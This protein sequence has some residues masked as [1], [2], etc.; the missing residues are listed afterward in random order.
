MPNKSLAYYINTVLL[1]IK[2]LVYSIV[3]DDTQNYFEQL[4]SDNFKEGT[5]ILNKE[6]DWQYYALSYFNKPEEFKANYHFDKDNIPMI[7]RDF[8]PM[9][10]NPIN[11][12]QYGL[13]NFNKYNKERDE[14]NLSITINMY[15]FLIGKAI[16]KDHALWFAYDV[17]YPKFNLQAPWYA[18]ITQAQVLSLVLRLYHVKASNELEEKLH[19]IFNSL[20]IPIERGGFLSHTPE[21]YLWIEEY[22]SHNKSYVLNG[23]LFCLIAVYEYSLVFPNKDNTQLIYQLTEGLFKSLHHYKRGKYWKYS[24]IHNTLSNIEY[25]GLHVGLIKHLWK[26]SNNEAFKLLYEEDERNMNWKAFNSF[27]GIT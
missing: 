5:L 4:W 8:S 10:Y 16:N 25:Q 13:I 12:A 15:N 21:G 7:R 18:G 24:R 6:F 9:F 23:Y 11:P 14:E 20:M 3:G 27:Y 19:L 26:L 2:G 1:K 22:P 17:D